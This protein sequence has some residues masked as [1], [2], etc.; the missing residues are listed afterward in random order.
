MSASVAG[1]EATTNYS[2]YAHHFN[3]QFQKRFFFVYQSLFIGKTATQ[4][5]ENKYSLPHVKD[6]EA[7]PSSRK[8]QLQYLCSPHLYASRSDSGVLILSIHV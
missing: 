5:C 4:E 7:L 2:A 3:L 6:S 8:T 1:N